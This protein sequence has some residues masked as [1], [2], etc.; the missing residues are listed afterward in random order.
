MRH[1]SRRPRHDET[2]GGDPACHRGFRVRRRRD[3]ADLDPGHDATA[4]RGPESAP[5]GS[6]RIGAR[7]DSA[8]P[9]S[10]ASKPAS[11]IRWTSSLTPHTAFRNTHNSGLGMR[12]RRRSARFGSTCSVAR[13]RLFTP[14]M[15]APDARA[16]SISASS[17]TS[18]R[19]SRPSRLRRVAQQRGEPRLLENPNDQ[20]DRGGAHRGALI[21]L[22]FIDDE[23]LAQAGQRRSARGLEVGVPG[24]EEGRDRS[25]RRWR[26]RPLLHRHARAPPHRARQRERPSRER[27]V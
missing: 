15:A 26:S 6:P 21:D 11:S 7:R 8:S 20:Q 19:T 12:G 25:G 5:A 13:S 3:A 17:C 18:T 22:E 9:I 27:H 16:R 24:A 2:D 1:P 10:T 23:V 4:S 14:M